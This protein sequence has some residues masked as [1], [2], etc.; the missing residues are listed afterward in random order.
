MASTSTTPLRPFYFQLLIFS[1]TILHSAFVEAATSTSSSPS[2]TSTS[3]YNVFSAIASAHPGTGDSGLQPG[4]VGAD[5]SSSSEQNAAGASG[6]EGGS[7]FN[8]PK[9]AMIAI[10]V[11]VGVVAIVGIVATVLWF[12]VKKRQWEIKETIRKSARKVKEGI[13]TPL[14]PRFPR[15]ARRE[16]GLER[17]QEPSPALL[18]EDRRG[19][20]VEKGF[21]TT[22]KISST[23]E[24][25]NESVDGDKQVNTK[26]QK[27][28]W[29]K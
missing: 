11:V 9:G 12:G 23:F 16:P 28:W 22:T 4:D 20:D 7:G 1:L 6:G 29:G 18:R 10:C 14:T 19:S 5:Q 13:M 2:S 15:H 24:I 25:Q 27:K 17:I 8:L 21:G 26:G 3:D